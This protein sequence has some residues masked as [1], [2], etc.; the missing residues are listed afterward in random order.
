MVI[1]LLSI[2]AL[3]R[4]LVRAAWRGLA[5]A[6]TLCVTAPV[7]AASAV[8]PRKPASIVKAHSDKKVRR[9]EPRAQ[10]VT[11][12]VKS[13][14]SAPP[15]APSAASTPM[16]MPP[17]AATPDTQPLAVLT[18]PPG[19]PLSAEAATQQTPHA[20]ENPYLAGWFRPTPASELPNLAAQQIGASTQWVV[21]GVKNLP[22]QVIDALPKIKRV[23][24]TGA[25]ELWV[26]SMKCPA[27]MVTGQYFLPADAMRDVVNGLLGTL[28]ESRMLTFDIQLVCS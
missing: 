18:P 23:F 22:G 19:N 2:R 11:P 24:P 7:Q 12:A 27:E 1:N 13:A 26:V 3:R 9:V 15:R 8:A 17:V 6:L 5:V 21:N 20:P 16:V 4:P 28:N 25:R 14:E 10:S